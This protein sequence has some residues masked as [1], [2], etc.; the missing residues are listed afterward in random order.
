MSTMDINVTI[1]GVSQGHSVEPRRR[2]AEFL[3]EDAGLLGTNVS[4]EAQICGACTVLVDGKPASACTFLAADTDG[5][6]VTTIEGVASDGVLSPV[7]AAFRDHAA[8]QCGFC[9][10]GF[11]LAATALLEECDDP[12]EEM[13]KHFQDGNVC[14]CT[15]YVQILEAV[16][17]A[18]SRVR[19]SKSDG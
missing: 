6:D 1:N 2:L 7:Q 5:R 3:R 14:R 8:L 4:C 18:A 15:G 12:D 13:I 10:P 19:E 9:T 16:R 17:D 11:V